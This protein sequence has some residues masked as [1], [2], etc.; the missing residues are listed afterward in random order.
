[1]LA[2]IQLGVLVQLLLLRQQVLL[3]VLLCWLFLR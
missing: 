1:M 3:Q 2:L